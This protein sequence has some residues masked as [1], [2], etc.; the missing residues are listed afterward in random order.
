M[1]ENQWTKL[2]NELGKEFPDLKAINEMK[3][4]DNWWLIFY[5]DGKGMR[6][7][8]YLN[9]KVIIDLLTMIKD[10]IYLLNLLEDIILLARANLKREV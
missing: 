9:K 6:I 8:R 1:N 4:E 2:F 3:V 5:G 7:S 10:D